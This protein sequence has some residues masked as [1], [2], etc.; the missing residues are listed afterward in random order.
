MVTQRESKESHWL[1]ITGKPPQLSSADRMEE[2]SVEMTG[3]PELDTGQGQQGLGEQ[4]I[5]AHASPL[6]HSESER[7]NQ[8]CFATATITDKPSKRQR[9]GIRHSKIS[10]ILFLRHKSSNSLPSQRPLKFQV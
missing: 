4:E 5:G 1:D 7:P 2:L 9:T 10:L 3:W 6:S 8:L